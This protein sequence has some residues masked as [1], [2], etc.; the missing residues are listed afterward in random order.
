MDGPLAWK[1]RDPPDHFEDV[2]I[3]IVLSD[4]AEC[5][6]SAECR[7]LGTLDPGRPISDSSRSCGD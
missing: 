3:L 1:R 5:V 2:V 4:A 6:Q 7:Y